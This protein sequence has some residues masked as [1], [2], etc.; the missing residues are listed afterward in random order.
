MAKTSEVFKN[1]L[2]FCTATQSRATVKSKKMIL[3]RIENNKELDPTITKIDQGYMDMYVTKA[4]ESGL[5]PSS[6]R[7]HL[8]VI[9]AFLTWA[10]E[11]G[12]K[13]QD[14]K[15]IRLRIKRKKK[16]ALTPAEVADIKNADT[17]NMTKAFVATRNAFLFM[18]Y[19][20]CR[21]SDLGKMR[22]ECI[23]RFEG[24]DVLVYTA[25]KTGK[26]SY[27]LLTDDAIM[28]LRDIGMRR[29]G[30]IFDYIPKLSTFS[31]AIKEIAEK[32]GL[33][34]PI[35]QTRT[36]RSGE[37]ITDVRPLHELVSAHTGRTTFASAFI[38]RGGGATT[39]Q[40]I[41]GHSSVKTTERYYE[42]T[43]DNLLTE[44]INVWK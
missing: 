4:L 31:V 29:D 7:Y 33:N 22:W 43:K 16:P 42:T 34:R 27:V 35:R 28:F 2:A 20:G 41:F 15:A 26:E 1:Y 10:R 3:G 9:G 13:I 32:A 44:Q 17:S 23:E 11:R 30:M 8:D 36:D 18:C 38:A 21:W 12:H 14:I 40:N 39:L 25:G 6:V 24:R 37:I 19:T 5:S